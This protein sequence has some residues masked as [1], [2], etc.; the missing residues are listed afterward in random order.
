VL[1]LLPLLP[2][3]LPLPPVGQY[4]CCHC[5]YCCRRCCCRRCR[6]SCC[7]FCRLPRLA[8]LLLPL[9]LPLP[10]SLLLLLLKLLVSL[11]PHCHCRCCQCCLQALHTHNATQG[12]KQSSQWRKLCYLKTH[13]RHLKMQP[14]PRWSKYV[15]KCK[16]Q[17]ASACLHWRCKCNRQM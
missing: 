6:R 8:L 15:F 11:L 7:C 10:L 16:L 4:S 1:T 17:P 2:L 5:H 13:A 12:S 3:L 14:I 9:S